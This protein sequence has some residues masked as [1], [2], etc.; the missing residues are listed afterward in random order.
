MYLETFF[1][2]GVGLFGVGISAAALSAGSGGGDF[3]RPVYS[4]IPTGRLLVG[5]AVRRSAGLDILPGSSTLRYHE[6]IPVATLHGRLPASPGSL[7]HNRLSHSS[8]TRCETFPSNLRILRKTSNAAQ[9]AL[10]H[11]HPFSH[12]PNEL[13]LSQNIS[14]S[15]KLY[16]EHTKKQY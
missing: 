7:A 1:P 6:K 2:V 10:R 12:Q 14:R 9:A 8:G 5:D 11:S 13:A 3:S 15:T 16:K 4:S